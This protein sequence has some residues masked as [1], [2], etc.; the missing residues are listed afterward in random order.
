LAKLDGLA[1]PGL[2]PANRLVKNPLFLK[3]V[4]DLF[5]IRAVAWKLT[6]Y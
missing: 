6:K 2:E 4:K 5:R 3:L 1:N